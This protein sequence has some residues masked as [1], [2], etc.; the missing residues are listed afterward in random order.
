MWL[1]FARR[2]FAEALSHYEL[3]TNHLLYTLL[4]YVPTR[5]LG[6]APW[7]LRLPALVA[8]VLLIPATYVVTARLYGRAAAL[9]A[10]ALV[11][12]SSLMVEY[13]ANA[14]G[15]GLMTLGF[16]LAV[17]SASRLLGTPRLRGWLTWA[18]P[19][20]LGLYA[21]PLMTLPVAALLAWIVLEAARAPDPRITHEAVRGV[22]VGVA[23]AAAL[24]T[25]LYAPVVATLGAVGFANA[26]GHA[27]GP[28]RS[29]AEAM[30]GLG[31]QA[32]SIWHS[33]HRNCHAPVTLALGAAALFAV[34]AH[35]RVGRQRV[36][37]T[38]VVLAFLLPLGALAWVRPRIALFAAPLYYAAA[39]AGL[40]WVIA[41]VV[42][43]RRVEGAAGAAAVGLFLLLGFTELRSRHVY[44][45]SET[46]AARDA[47]QLAD[48]FSTVIRPG[49]V[50]LHARAPVAYHLEKRGVP[51]HDANVV[52]ERGTIT[53]VYYDG[54]PP[55]VPPPMP[56][57]L[58]LVVDHARR[59]VPPGGRAGDGLPAVAGTLAF[60]G[61]PSLVPREWRMVHD[62]NEASVWVLTQPDGDR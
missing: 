25:V 54:P 4:L 32:A 7:V 14:R 50:L 53:P 11:A 8:G 30:P 3:A 46:G 60:R 58:F 16:L 28:V 29:W 31:A 57:R 56:R 33:W 26:V 40:A 21:V 13:S 24:A 43:E 59:D 41:R 17:T 6:D 34:V 55:E 36:S 49:D 18:V 19:V 62:V 1:Q 20:A 22:G 45:S 2:P 5:T 44:W 9:L 42:E 23:A 38:A 52:N 15:Y 37:L 39:A 12:G 27:A 35:R 61:F 51:V 47:V 48:Y 10:A